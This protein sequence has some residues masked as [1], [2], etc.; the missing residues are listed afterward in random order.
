[1]IY[2]ISLWQDF[3]V[4]LQHRSKPQYP[5]N[6]KNPRQNH[7]PPFSTNYHF[8]PY[9]HA[10]THSPSQ[11]LHRQTPAPAPR[12]HNDTNL[13]EPKNSIKKINLHLSSV[14]RAAPALSVSY[15]SGHILFPRSAPKGQQ[16]RVIGLWSLS[17]LSK[18]IG[19]E[20]RRCRVITMIRGGRFRAQPPPPPPPSCPDIERLYIS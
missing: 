14:A 19:E 1:M 18:S 17:A 8:S 6:H 12:N 3:S 10:R 11:P 9:A 13:S 4:L 16:R 15:L 2:I 20:R 7:C 5:S